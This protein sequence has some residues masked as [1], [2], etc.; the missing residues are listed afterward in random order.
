MSQPTRSTVRNLLL[1][2]LSPQGFALLQMHLEPVSLKRGDVLIE[3]NQPIEHT[4]FLEDGIASIVGTVDSHR[5]EIGICGREGMSGTAVLLGTDRA[6]HETFIQVAGSALRIRSDDLQRA[7]HQSP[8]LQQRLLRYVQAFQAQI[9]QTALSN[10]SDRVEERLA[11]WVLMCHDRLDGDDLPL[12]HEFVSIMLGVS[13]PSVTL[14]IQRLEGAKMIK[15]RRGL[16]TILSR[17]KLEEIAGDSYGLP[18][19]EYRR[20]MARSWASPCG[21]AAGEFAEPG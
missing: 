18:E 3:P 7:T 4:Y 16:L 21:D 2:A 9:A 20:L 1:H 14:A 15:A 11:R 13:R 19:A 17:P 8:S 12:T 10:A 5:V 6:P